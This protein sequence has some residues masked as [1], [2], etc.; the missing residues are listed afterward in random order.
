MT[1]LDQIR[2][3]R[4]KSK[5]RNFVQ[6]YDLIVNLKDLN[7]KKD[8]NKIDEIFVLPKE[9]GKQTSLTLFSES[10]GKMEG[11]K[12]I[13]GSEIEELGKNKKALKKLI[14][15]TDFFFS[16]P[17]LMLVVGKHLGKFLAPIGKMPKPIVGEVD[18]MMNKYKNGVRVAI[19][20]QPIIHMP[21]GAENMKEEEVAENIE[22]VLVFLKTKLP[23]GKNNISKIY[24]KLTMSSPIKLEV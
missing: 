20:K 15:Q 23:K 6:R 14:K 21:V 17:K 8:E 13:K 18:K 16:E 1:I 22:S 4:K 10:I 24:L 19:K 11:C 12:I 7:L 5:K 2:E 3:L 9:S